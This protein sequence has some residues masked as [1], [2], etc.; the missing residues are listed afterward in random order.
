MWVSPTRGSMTFKQVLSIIGE[1]LEKGFNYEAYRLMV[2]CDSQTKK[3][4]TF[5]TAIILH[6]VG[7]GAIFFYKKKTVKKITVLQKRI[8]SEAAYS[9]GVASELANYLSRLN[10]EVQVEIHV[11]IGEKGETR[12]ILK[13]VIGMIAGSGFQ[14]MVKPESIAASWCADRFNKTETAV[15]NE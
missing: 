10:S 11:D 6:K 1:E 14:C 2:G 15:T 12:N 7:R 8:Y 4:T 9:L 13:E 5:V 3:N